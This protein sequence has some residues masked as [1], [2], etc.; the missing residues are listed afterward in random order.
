MRYISRSYVDQR[1]RCPRKAYWQYLAPSERGSGWDSVSSNEHLGIGLSV[2][3][4]METLMLKGDPDEALSEAIA[5]ANTFWQALGPEGVSLVGGLLMGWVR[6]R[7]QAFLEEYEI[8]SVEREEPVLVLAP[9]LGLRARIDVVVRQRATGLIFVFNWKTSGEKKDWSLKWQ[10]DLQSLTE[11]LAVESSTGVRVDGVIY[12]GFYKG[13]KRADG[14]WTSPTVNGYEKVMKDG[15]KVW[16]G[17][18]TA[19]WDRFHA[20]DFPVGGHIGWINFLPLALMEEIYPRSAP[21]F[22]D[23]ENAEKLLQEITRWETDANTVL[24]G[25]SE[26]DKLLF[27]E[28]HPG[29]FNCSRCPFS[30]GAGRSCAGSEGF[31][32]L[33]EVGRIIPRVDHHGEVV[34]NG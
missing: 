19:G 4:G 32:G 6:A 10:S 31:E 1:W 14:T 28:R 23:D 17:E 16:K 8:L 15:T 22:R 30:L 26:E 3:K 9:G 27:F 11:A 33:K 29:H 18:W 7:W 21:V 12:E 2:H 20:R 13:Q 5:V 25:G 34:E 24:E